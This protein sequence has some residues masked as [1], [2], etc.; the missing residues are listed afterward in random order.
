MLPGGEDI[1]DFCVGI[2]GKTSDINLFRA[3]QHKFIDTQKFLSNKAYIKLQSPSFVG[4]VE[5]SVTEHFPVVNLPFLNF[6]TRI[7]CLLKA[8]M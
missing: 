8:L 5:R 4:W 6:Y 2:L 7:S 3:N 1:V